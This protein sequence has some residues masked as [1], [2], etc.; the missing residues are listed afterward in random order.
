MN[1]VQDYG[2]WKLDIEPVAAAGMY[3]AKATI[4]RTST[5]A[6]D[7]YF[8]YT[9]KNLGVSDTP[10]G[11]IRWAADWLRGWIDENT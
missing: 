4:S 2:D 10:E 11:A 9:F 1:A 5:D 6:D 3:T 8:S 7:G